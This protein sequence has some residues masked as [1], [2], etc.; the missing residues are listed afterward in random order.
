L[1]VIVQEILTEAQTPT[2]AEQLGLPKPLTSHIPESLVKSRVE[3]IYGEIFTKINE[4]LQ[5]DQL[6]VEK[7]RTAAAAADAALSRKEPADMSK[8]AVKSEVNDALQQHGLVFGMDA[9]MADPAAKSAC[10][11]FVDCL[12]QSGKV[13]SP[14]A[15]VGHNG[16]DGKARAKGKGKE[17]TTPTYGPHK[18]KGKG[19]GKLA[20]GLHNGKGK[21]N[22]AQPQPRPWKKKGA[23]KGG[24]HTSPDKGKTGG[25]G[26][27]K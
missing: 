20:Y 1:E 15:G 13:K 24:K 22:S 27:K 26:G 2:L 4:Q 21:E 25:K 19:A 8:N 5:A 17:I 18:G 16:K 10:A 6:A 3:A 23:G 14:P 7:S 9:T 12:P 11:E